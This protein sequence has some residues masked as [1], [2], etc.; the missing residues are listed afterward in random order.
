ML[1][2]TDLLTGS[3]VLL[4]LVERVGTFLYLTVMMQRYADIL[5][6]IS[7][8]MLLIWIRAEKQRQ[9]ISR[10]FGAL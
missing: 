8:K 9:K 5:L 1:V 4:L 3:T 10:C 7:N 6:I 2:K